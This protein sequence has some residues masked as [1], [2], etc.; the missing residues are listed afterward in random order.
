MGSGPR[1]PRAVVDSTLRVIGFQNLRVVDTSIMPEVVNPNTHAGAYAI[2]EK[3]SEMIL[4]N[5]EGYSPAHVRHA[6]GHW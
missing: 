6:I 1:D 3:A 4:Q 2:A 5:A